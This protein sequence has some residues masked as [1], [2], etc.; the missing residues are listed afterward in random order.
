M[1]HGFSREEAFGFRLPAIGLE[2]REIILL[3]GARVPASRAAME[4]NWF[5]PTADSHAEPGRLLYAC[6][7]VN[8]LVLGM[9][10]LISMATMR[11]DWSSSSVA[12]A[13]NTASPFRPGIEINTR[14][15][16]Q[17]T[18]GSRLR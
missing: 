3:R 9:Q 2:R 10:P 7:G 8:V 17:F 15:S 14:F 6:A 13:L 5:V 11:P 12:G 16:T 4:M 18:E 1:I